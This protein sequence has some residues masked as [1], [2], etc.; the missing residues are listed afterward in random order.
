MKAFQ[1]VSSANH[2]ELHVG[3]HADSW[4]SFQDSSSFKTSQA[5]AVTNR[6]SFP[7]LGRHQ[8]DTTYLE[9]SKSNSNSSKVSTKKT[10]EQPNVMPPDS[11]A[12]TTT[13][14]KTTTTSHNTTSAIAAS[15]PNDEYKPSRKRASNN[16]DTTQIQSHITK[17][18]KTK[19]A[20]NHLDAVQALVSSRR[21][22]QQIIDNRSIKS[23][24]PTQ[25]QIQP[26]WISAQDEAGRTYFYH[27]ITRETSWK[28]PDSTYIVA[29]AKLKKKLRKLKAKREAAES[30]Y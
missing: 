6:P 3:S 17:K 11:E 16:I 29:D 19:H 7:K 1:S 21:Q 9:K 4:N 27:N 26:Q 2:K 14:T 24:V 10:I 5:K 12:T 13:T 18:S 28:N 25:I 23:V 8:K 30:N 15:L 20:A 22:G